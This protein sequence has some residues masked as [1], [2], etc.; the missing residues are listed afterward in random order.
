MY[1]PILRWVFPPVALLC[2]LTPLHAQRP[3]RARPAPPYVP[4]QVVVGF[5]RGDAG[6]ATDVAAA[7][8]AVPGKVI[9]RINAQVFHLPGGRDAAAAIAGIAKLPGVRYAEPNY[10]RRVLLAAPNDPGYNLIDYTV[11]PFNYDEEGVATYYQWTLHQI[12]AVQAWSIYPGVYYTQ[13][14]KPTNAPKLAVIDTGIDWG[15][16]DAIP[17]ADF[18]NAGGSSTD[19][20]QGGQ[21]DLAEGRNLISGALD[22]TDFADDYG[23]GTAVAGT[24]AA[25]AN[26]GTTLTSGIAGIGYHAQI[27][28]IKTF[29]STGNGT[30][31]D[32]ATSIV[33]AADHGALIINISAGDYFYSQAEQDAVDYAWSK[34][35]L[36]VAAAGN[37]GD[38]NNRPMYPAAL[39]GV[40]AVAATTWP[41]DYPASYSNFGYYITV[42]A[43]AGDASVVPLG[44]WGTWCTMPTEHVPLH[45]L[46]WPGEVAPYEY[47][48]GTSLAS[49]IAAGLASLYA[50]YKGITQGTPNG[51]LTIYQALCRGCDDTMGTP[52]W[53]PNVGWGRIN[54]YH[55]LLEDDWRGSTV[56]GIR[57][58]AKYKDTVVANATVKAYI[59]GNPTPVATATSKP[60]AMYQLTGLAPGTYDVQA[61]Y[62]G[63]KQTIYGVPVVASCD[64]PRVSFNIGV[65]VPTKGLAWVGTSGYESDGVDPDT[66]DPNVTTFTFKV[67]Y[68]DP[69]GNAPRRARCL[70]QR[71][72]CG[73][74]WQASRSIALTK[75]SGDIA[76][77]AIYSGS[78]TLA[79]LVYK[80]R[81]DFQDSAGAAA[82]GDP[83]AFQ[84]GPM[85][86]G[87]P[88]VCWT[89][90]TNFVSDGVNPDSGPAGT[91]FQFQVLYADSAGDAP[92]TSQLLIRRDG[93]IFRRKPMSAAAAGDLRLGKVYRISCTLTD[94]GTYEYRFNFV[95]AS[96]TALGPP[97][98]WTA[99]PTIT[100]TAGVAITGLAA[101]PTPAGAQLTFI[102]SGAANVTATIVNVAGRPIKTIVADKP[103]E[104][105]LQTLLWDRRADSGLAVPAGLYLI[106]VTARTG[107][108]GQVEALA[109][110]NLR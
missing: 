16:T 51:P 85:I 37:E 82:T 1:R 7:V 95:D 14:T 41:D 44:F 58:Q 18:I 105:G 76:T 62:F 66:G 86:D 93:R 20:A 12:D 107:D 17:H 90:A 34:G 81:F 50:A 89:G 83:A 54:A 46:G 56:G 80:C 29:D 99:G 100:G 101:V 48:F 87:R 13:A 31:A 70:I 33:Y 9:P 96:G 47:Q 109:A 49:P 3:P 4:G 77:G 27:L 68:T 25:S 28:P 39:D 53:N 102:L 35:S 106:R 73:A 84:Q 97:A 36:V 65:A 74:T 6:R 72:D 24:A 23:H 8:G 91:S 64:R 42:G 32:T 26:N 88:W 57:G 15:G 21:I 11:A 104:A 10:R 40:V 45:D 94:P 19:A 75:E 103:L 69:T 67:Q 43:P 22:P 79:N 71:K 110:V 2:L 63:E 98:N 60:D 55:T 92:A 52:G 78:A 30:E 38:S 5:A 59:P 61:S 108:G